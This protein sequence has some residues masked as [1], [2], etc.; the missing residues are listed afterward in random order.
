MVTKALEKS[1]D[2]V[3]RQENEEQDGDGTPQGDDKTLNNE[4]ET[5]K[6][7]ERLEIWHQCVDEFSKR[8]L[9]VPSDKL[10][11][12]AGLAAV[13]NDETVG[14]YLA[15][16][17]SKNIGTGLAWARVYSLLSPAPVYRA[18]SWSW[19][20]IDG[21]ISSLLS[22]PLTLMDDYALDPGWIERYGTKLVE[23]H[24]I[25]QD[26]SNPYMGVLEGSYI[27]VEGACASISQLT[28]HLRGNDSFN[29]TLGLDQSWAFDC[30]CC[31]PGLEDSPDKD[32]VE[33]TKKVVN[34][35]EHHICMI[36]QGDAWRAENSMVDMLVLRWVDQDQNILERV[37]FLRLSH[38]QSGRGYANKYDPVPI[39][40]EFGAIGWERK[41][42][43]LVRYN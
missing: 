23:H 33:E 8:A 38:D 13:I 32:E 22:W 27:V 40:E 37:G 31:A 16:I 2:T 6:L 20:S 11:A 19:A 17:W 41:V 21:N 15:G 4:A 14:D 12:M 39:H 29:I 18:P 43:K 24:I 36:L 26:P 5:H 3:K 7:I 34:D 28:K 30:P 35:T 1:E 25:L 10:P 9:T 42:M